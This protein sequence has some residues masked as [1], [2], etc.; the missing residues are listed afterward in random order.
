MRTPHLAWK[1]DGGKEQGFS[2][3]KW[4]VVESTDGVLA[5]SPPTWLID[6][7]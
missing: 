5:D 2:C 7:G 4:E 6:G 3:R 1:E